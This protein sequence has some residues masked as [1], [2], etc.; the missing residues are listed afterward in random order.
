MSKTRVA[1][2]FDLWSLASLKRVQKRGGHRSMTAALGKSVEIMKVVQGQVLEGFSDLI[3]I[4]HKT[5]QEKQAI[6]PSIRRM[7]SALA[8]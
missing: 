8:E 3:V 7:L 4:N 6:I 2:T 1:F 5:N